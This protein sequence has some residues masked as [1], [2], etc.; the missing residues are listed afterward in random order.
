MNFPRYA[1]D[2]QLD[3]MRQECCGEIA[4]VI[5]DSVGGL[6]SLAE[7]CDGGLHSIG[8]TG[9]SR[10]AKGWFRTIR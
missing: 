10:N 1:A 8:A 5:F 6:I 2:I 7:K 3:S 9:L 4:A